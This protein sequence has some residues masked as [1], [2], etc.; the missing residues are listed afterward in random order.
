MLSEISQKKR[1]DKYRMISLK[2]DLIETE[3]KMVINRGW[4]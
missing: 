1:K 3:T 4:R 2:A